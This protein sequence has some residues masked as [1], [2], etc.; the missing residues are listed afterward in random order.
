MPIAVEESLGAR[1]L[2]HVFERAAMINGR[3]FRLQ[4]NALLDGVLCVLCFEL[5]YEVSRPD[6]VQVFLRLKLLCVE[7]YI[8]FL[9]LEE[10][11]QVFFDRSPVLNALV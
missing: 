8:G 5:L 2:C 4:T 10:L 7:Q 1:A 3:V 9:L 6:T 11:D